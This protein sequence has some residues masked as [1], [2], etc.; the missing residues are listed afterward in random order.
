LRTPWSTTLSNSK[1]KPLIIQRTLSFYFYLLLNRGT[2][3]DIELVAAEEAGAAEV[4]A[5]ADKTKR[6]GAAELE[7]IAG[8]TR[9]AEAAT[10]VEMEAEG[11]AAGAIVVVDTPP[12]AAAATEVEAAGAAAAA[13]EVPAEV[14]ATEVEPAEV[15]P[16]Y[17][18]LRLP[19]VAGGA[20]GST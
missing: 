11:E 20:G 4:E 14:A 10:S 2:R 8:G 12:V 6:A 7:A 9:R 13:A 1:Y 3:T 15:E 5:I 18:R 17:T 16:V 19:K